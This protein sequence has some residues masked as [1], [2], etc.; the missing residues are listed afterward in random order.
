MLLDKVIGLFTSLSNEI[1]TKRDGKGSVRFFVLFCF[2]L[3][4]VCLSTWM[5]MHHEL[6]CADGEPL[7][8]GL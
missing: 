4:Y 5:Y 2:V 1:L 6:V 7:P 8:Q 3:F